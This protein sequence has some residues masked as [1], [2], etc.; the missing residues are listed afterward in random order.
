M[1]LIS[2]QLESAELLT[3]KNG[4]RRD[5]WVSFHENVAAFA[6]KYE[7]RPFRP[8]QLPFLQL[9]VNEIAPEVEKRVRVTIPR[10]IPFPGGLKF[11][12]FHING[13][14]YALTP[15]QWKEFSSQMVE[16]LSQRLSKAG[17]IPFNGLVEISETIG[18]Y[19]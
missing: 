11:P 13:E 16:N 8:E 10:P 9:P 6:K 5:I 15:S 2:N 19:C 14:V 18:A 17:S 4:G 3:L 1:A 7:M 12:H